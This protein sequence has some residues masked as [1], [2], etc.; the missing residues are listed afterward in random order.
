MAKPS[1][2]QSR[3]RDTT[4][5]LRMSKCTAEY[6]QALINPFTGPLACVPV[7]PTALSYKF[8]VWSKG[9]LFTSN[10]TG[11]GF[12]IA[13]PTTAVANDVVA[14]YTTGATFTG[15]VLTNGGAGV[16]NAVTNSPFALAAF[17]DVAALAAYRVVCAGIRIRYVGTELNRG[18]QIIALLDPTGSSMIGNSSVAMLAE[19]QARKFP[20]N[21]TWTTVTWRPT[22]NQDYS[23]QI[24]PAANSPASLFGPMAIMVIAPNLT[25]IEFEWEFS[26]VYEVNG[27]NIRGQTVTEVDPQGQAAVYGTSLTSNFAIPHQGDP[28]DHA[29]KF[30]EETAHVMG[31]VTTYM[32]SAEEVLSKGA[33]LGGAL[34]K[35]GATA[36][37][38]L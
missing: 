20:V 8:R 14:L 37:K 16:N 30:L 13:D 33:A 27:R 23:F 19:P 21:R 1:A 9:T 25:P 6:A 35:I 12:I 36:A 5:V 18:G 15:S 31:K 38:L 11:V 4:Q 2:P 22:D 17:G 26:A 7:A 32:T 3:P 34:F 29:I 10:V 28:K 24:N